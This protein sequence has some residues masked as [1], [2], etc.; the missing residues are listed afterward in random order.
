MLLP[1]VPLI[2]SLMIHVTIPLSAAADVPIYAVLQDYPYY[3]QLLTSI[4][5]AGLQA[6]ALKAIPGNNTP[7]PA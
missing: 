7:P 1:S 5:T 3:F 2:F 4:T 6:T